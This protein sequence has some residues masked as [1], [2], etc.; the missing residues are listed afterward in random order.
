VTPKQYIAAQQSKNPRRRVRASDLSKDTIKRL[1]EVA[2]VTG[3]SSEKAFAKVDSVGDYGE[4]LLGLIREGL[5]RETLRL[6]EEGLIAVGEIG[7]QTPNAYTERV[8]AG[9]AILFNSGLRDFVYRVA[10]AFSTRAQPKTLV[11]T[12]ATV[13]IEE[14]ARVVAEIFWWFS[15]TGMPFGPEYQ[16]QPHQILF[17]HRL[18]TAAEMFLLA[19]ELSHAV[20]M[21]TAG[22][23]ST[24]PG[25]SAAQVDEFMADGEGITIVLANIISGTNPSSMGP[26]W[27]YAGAEFALQ[28]YAALEALGV[29]FAESHPPAAE[30]LSFLRNFISENLGDSTSWDGIHQPAHTIDLVFQALT[31]TILNPSAEQEK[32]FRRAEEEIA[33]EL[34][35]LLGRC[36]GGAVPDYATFYPEASAILNRG[37]SSRISRGSR[38]DYLQICPEYRNRRCVGRGLDCVPT[39]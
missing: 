19:H 35:E 28:I 31:K 15:E 12:Q 5:S 13:P 3:H 8:G 22:E 39:I 17:A 16:I 36:S 34:I 2:K 11:G 6:L 29:E 1:E 30:R 18:A 32:F 27:A 9:C 24:E 37:Y 20:S 14:T 23:S 7:D 25:L 33:K 38:K 4:Y 21:I 10:R 26:E